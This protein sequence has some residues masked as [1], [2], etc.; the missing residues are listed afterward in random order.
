MSTQVAWWVAAAGLLVTIMERS[1]RPG[2][3]GWRPG[4][5]RLTRRQPHDDTVDG[6]GGAAAVDVLAERARVSNR[7]LTCMWRSETGLRPHRWLLTGR[8]KPSSGPVGEDRHRWRTDGD[9][10]WAR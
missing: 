1:S 2:P 6:C 10:L 4:L 5:E 9:S 3:P 7:T 8:I